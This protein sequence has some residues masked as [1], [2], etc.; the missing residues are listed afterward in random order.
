MYPTYCIWG[1]KEEGI[2]GAGV[3]VAIFGTNSNRIIACLSSS[4]SG[5]RD[6]Q[7]YIEAEGAIQLAM[8]DIEKLPG[9]NRFQGKVLFGKKELLFIHLEKNI[10]ALLD[11]W[12]KDTQCKNLQIGELRSFN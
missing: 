5:I 10:E 4:A 9:F 7:F 1:T 8:K 6:D 12:E 2:N 3:R 11:A